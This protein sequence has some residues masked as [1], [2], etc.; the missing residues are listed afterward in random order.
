MNDISNINS[1]DEDDKA[2]RRTIL[3]V[4]LGLIAMCCGVL[5]AAAL[6]W[7]KPDPQA[8]IA[9]Y[10]PSPTPTASST[11]TRTPTPVATATETSTP[12]PNLTATTEILQV[13]ESAIAF[14][15]TATNAAGTWRVVLTDTF[16]SNKNKWLNE[17]ADDEFAKVN[18]QVTDGKYIWDATAHQSFIGW[19]RTNIKTVSDF[20]LSVEVRQASGPDSADYGIIFREDDKGNFY[21]FGINQRGQYVLYEY[22]GE[23]N[24]LID[25]TETDLIRPGETN[26]L[27]MIAEGSQFTFFINNQY[28]T[29]ITDEHITKGRVGLAIEMAQENDQAVFEF[30][31]LEVRTP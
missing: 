24:T 2:S 9:Q 6:F 29:S 25:F 20:Y 14:Q 15:S 30:D 3:W 17:S 16:D 18:Y 7:F 26:H 22:F 12:T 23:W 28:L 5:F 1:F 21:Y 13:T 27:T 19:V 11:P 8:L 31:N 4:S 10:F